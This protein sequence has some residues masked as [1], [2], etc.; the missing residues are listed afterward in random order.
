MNKL[1]L[2]SLYYKYKF[3]NLRP[4]IEKINFVS[5]NVWYKFDF[6]YPVFVLAVLRKELSK[7][8]LKADYTRKKR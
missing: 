6:G 4:G 2:T 8:M 3:L 1:P 7:N 5:P